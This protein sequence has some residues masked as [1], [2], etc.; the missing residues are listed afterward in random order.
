VERGEQSLRDTA[1][2]LH[3]SLEALRQTLQTKYREHMSAAREVTR[4]TDLE[5]AAA[6]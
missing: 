2:G 1:A 4:D 5:A 3:I 6:E